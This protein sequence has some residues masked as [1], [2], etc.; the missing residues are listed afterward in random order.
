[1]LKHGRV[2]QINSGLIDEEAFW[3][4]LIY[5]DYI[6]YIYILYTIHGTMVLFA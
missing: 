1:M 6:D 3:V 5:M 2:C 4:L